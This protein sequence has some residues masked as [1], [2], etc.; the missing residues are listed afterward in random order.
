MKITPSKWKFER[1][2]RLA[3]ETWE[4][5]LDSNSNLMKFEYVDVLFEQPGKYDDENDFEVIVIKFSLTRPLT[6][7]EVCKFVT[8][9]ADLG[10]DECDVV[11]EGEGFSVM[12]FWWD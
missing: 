2:D 5:F 11:A 8:M 12:R 6:I 3:T 1:D 9:I 7:Q 10:P 4:K